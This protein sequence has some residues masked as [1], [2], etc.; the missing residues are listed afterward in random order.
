MPK[1]QKYRDVVR[2]LRENGWVLIRRG[3]GDHEIWGLPEARSSDEKHSVPHHREVSA[4]VIGDLIKKL[5][6]SPKSWR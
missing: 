6:I 5:P 2:V 1:P 3:K 4:G